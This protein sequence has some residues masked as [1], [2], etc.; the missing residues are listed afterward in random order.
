MSIERVNEFYNE[1]TKSYEK[2]NRVYEQQFDNMQRMNQ[3]WFDL[4]SKSWEEQQQNQ[5]EKR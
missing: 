1:F 4:F 5:N 2:I 3:K